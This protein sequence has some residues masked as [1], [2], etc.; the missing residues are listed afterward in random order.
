MPPPA[1]P[2]PQARADLLTLLHTTRTLYSSYQRILT[3]TTTTRSPNTTT[4]ELTS[5]RTDLSSHLADLTSDLH[6]LLAS[7][8]AV[9]QAPARYGIAPDEL[10]RRR[11]F[12]RRV[13]LEVDG[14]QDGISGTGGVGSSSNL[15]DPSSFDREDEDADGDAYEGFEQ[16]QQLEIM[17]AQDSTL[18][19]V[20]HT[21]GT[22]RQQADSMGREL[23]EQRGML[24]EVEVVADRVGGKLASGLERV[25][26]VIRHNEDRWSSCCIGLLIAVLIVLL[27]LLL[28]L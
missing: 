15:P 1:D 10:A 12:V 13:G 24:E 2:Y 21:V 18:D 11:E 27:V 3:T 7:V 25:G 14:M 6:D 9:E 28:V 8:S 20:F 5:A 4:P 26:W 23:E 19:S 22:L 17:Q 16:E